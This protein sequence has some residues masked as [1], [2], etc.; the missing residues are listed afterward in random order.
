MG[1]ESIHPVGLDETQLK[2]GIDV[3]VDSV[4]MNEDRYHAQELARKY[5]TRFL[6]VHVF[7]S[8]ENVWKERVTT[9]FDSMN[10]PDFATWESIQHQRRDFRVWEP[11]TALFIDSVQ[12]EEQ[13]FQK[14]MGYAKS[15][16]PNLEPLP[17]IQLVKGSY[18]A[19]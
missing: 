2:I 16:N 1:F 7:V 11:D 8:D 13:N 5:N 19:L 6:P 18:H 15:D 14:I 4:F 3:I 9:R 10:K 12:A 17:M